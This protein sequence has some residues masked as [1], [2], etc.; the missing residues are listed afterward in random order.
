MQIQFALSFEPNNDTFKEWLDKAK[1][2]REES[3]DEK[4]NAYKIRLVR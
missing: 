3:G 2:A 4:Q 1:S